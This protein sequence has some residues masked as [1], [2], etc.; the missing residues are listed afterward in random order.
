MCY[1]GGAKSAD[2]RARSAPFLQPPDVGMADEPLR[3][4]SC[5]DDGMDAWVAVD[6][7]HQLLQ[8]VGDFGAEQVMRAAVEPGD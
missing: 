6:P 2:R 8:L 5:D 4:R 7:V 1:G 3:M